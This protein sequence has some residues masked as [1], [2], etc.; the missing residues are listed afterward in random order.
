MRRPVIFCSFSLSGEPVKHTSEL[1][2]SASVAPSRRQWAA[3]NEQ[4]SGAV[5]LHNRHQYAG[6]KVKGKL[7]I[8]DIFKFAHECGHFPGQIEGLLS[9]QIFNVALQNVLRHFLSTV[10]S[11]PDVNQ[12]YIL[13]SELVWL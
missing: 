8:R 2:Y 11:I 3:N 9:N 4:H 12:T 1:H 7:H 6:V 5:I 10:F 13:I